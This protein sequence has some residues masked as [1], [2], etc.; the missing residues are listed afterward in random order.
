VFLLAVFKISPLC[1]AYQPCRTP[2]VAAA[3]QL[4][5]AD[6]AAFAGRGGLTF[7]PVINGAKSAK[8][9]FIAVPKNSAAALAGV[10]ERP[11]KL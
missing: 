11:I 7:L 8:S 6:P 3:A 4:Y 1:R 9:L 10:S 2:A 5:Q